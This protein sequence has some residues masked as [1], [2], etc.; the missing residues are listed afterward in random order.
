M[1]SL[2]LLLLRYLF[3]S[4]LYEAGRLLYRALPRRQLVQLILIQPLLIGTAAIETAS[5]IGL[6]LFASAVVQPESLQARINLIY[7]LPPMDPTTLVIYLGIAVAAGLYLASFAT[8]ATGYITMRFSNAVVMTLKNRLFQYYIQ[9]DHLYHTRAEHGSATAMSRISHSVNVVAG[10]IVSPSISIS[11]S[12]FLMC[13]VIG[14][15]LYVTPATLLFI[16]LALVGSAYY[17]IYLL[18]IPKLKKNS[19]ISEHANQQLTQWQREALTGLREWILYDKLGVLLTFFKS[20]ARELMRTSVSNGVYSMM[21]RHIVELS[22]M[23]A[24]VVMSVYL[25]VYHGPEK[26]F[27]ILTAYTIAFYKLMP[28]CNGI[29]GALITI[30]SSAGSAEKI[31]H[32][33]QLAN[34]SEQFIKAQV[35][36]R[37]IALKKSMVFKNI[38]F[39]YPDSPKPTL[40]DI[41]FEI[42]AGSTVGFMGESG[43]GKS[44]LMDIITGL[45]QPSTGEVWVDDCQLN[46]NSKHAWQAQIGYVSQ[47]VFLYNG[48]IA[49]NISLSLEDDANLDEALITRI[50]TVIGLDPLIKSLPDGIHTRVGESGAH[51]SGGQRQRLGIAR[52]LYRDPA[53]MIF[54]EST[55]ALDIQTERNITDYIGTLSDK[56]V[57]IISHRMSALLPC[58]KIYTLKAGALASCSTHAEL[59]EQHAKA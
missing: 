26:T 27:A 29:Y 22:A 53:V 31:E 48:T 44:T 43:S 16:A 57:L 30:R 2:N 54:D 45:L 3:G 14:A 1:R 19:R 18:L 25:V 12:L 47:N 50:L 56:T 52:V 17:G 23:S 13:T 35:L 15:L 32:D 58:D 59:S 8:I 34:Q 55:N 37:T 51:L 39:V 49:Q 4:A 38:C 41:N 24:M 33:I 7:T 11:K 28:A 21:P 36:D 40:H 46:H 20:S 6:V 42:A 10:G 5:A 9:Q